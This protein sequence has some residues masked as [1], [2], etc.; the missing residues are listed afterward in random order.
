MCGREQ[1]RGKLARRSDAVRRTVHRIRHIFSVCDG[2]PSARVGE[3]PGRFRRVGP[4]SLR[5]VLRKKMR[6]G[7]ET[8]VVSFTL[9]KAAMSAL[10]RLGMMSALTRDQTK[11]RDW[12]C[13]GKAM[14]VFLS[15]DMRFERGRTEAVGLLVAQ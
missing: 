8:H 6:H 7:S 9:E 15:F 2:M 11:R 1:K 10:R 12:L 5:S 13:R 4:H 14:R 3:Y